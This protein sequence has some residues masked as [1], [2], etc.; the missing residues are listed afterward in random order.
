M[1]MRLYIIYIETL[2]IWIGLLCSESRSLPPSHIHNL[3]NILLSHTHRHTYTYTHTNMH[4]HTL[5]HY[6]IVHM[7]SYNVARVD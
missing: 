7:H 4:A 3:T 2:S 5:I 1:A 6:D